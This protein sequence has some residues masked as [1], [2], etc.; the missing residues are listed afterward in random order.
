MCTQSER[1][2]GAWGAPGPQPV[3]SRAG[4][5]SM[6]AVAQ[7]Q[8]PSEPPGWHGLPARVSQ[9]PEWGK[10]PLVQAAPWQNG[11]NS[12]TAGPWPGRIDR[13]ERATVRGSAHLSATY[14]R[15]ARASRCSWRTFRS[16]EQ[17]TSADGNTKTA[18]RVCA[19]RGEDRG[20]GGSQSGRAE[21]AGCLAMS[22]PN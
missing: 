4:L 22:G 15:G 5:T 14:G 7:Q 8:S 17:K 6:W 11:R 1:S 13:E 2:R 3:S 20:V 21:P 9:A 18:E 10:E 16:T 19:G 12:K